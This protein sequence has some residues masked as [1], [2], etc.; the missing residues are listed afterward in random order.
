M[1][2]KQTTPDPQRWKCQQPGAQEKEPQKIEQPQR[3]AQ[4]KTKVKFPVPGAEVSLWLS[5]AWLKQPQR[6]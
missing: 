4:A 2:V 6:Q 1:A 3:V 5:E